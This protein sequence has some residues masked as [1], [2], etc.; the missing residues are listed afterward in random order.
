MR[1]C[2]A[3][4]RLEQNLRRTRQGSGGRRRRSPATLPASCPRASGAALAVDWR[5]AASCWN[6]R[7]GNVHAVRTLR[8]P[9]NGKLE[10]DG[11]Y[12]AYTE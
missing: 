6:L 11:R 7:G 3:R 9:S 5:N 10:T 1:S 8:G 12:F 2:S 4:S